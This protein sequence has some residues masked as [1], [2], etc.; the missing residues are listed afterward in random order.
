MTPEEIIERK[1]F[2][3]W[4]AVELLFAEYRKVYETRQALEKE[5]TERF[6]DLI[7]KLEANMRKIADQVGFVFG[8][9]HQEQESS[10]IK[11]NFGNAHDLDSGAE[12]NDIRFSFGE[13]E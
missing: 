12:F 7:K 5:L 4:Q 9:D 10:E 6:S 3:K 1:K 11:F 13:E 2:L 8:D